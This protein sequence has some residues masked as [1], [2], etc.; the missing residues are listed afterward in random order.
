[1]AANNHATTTHT[2]PT[3]PAAKIHVYGMLEQ[4]P[5]PTDERDAE[6]Q[7]LSPTALGR[8]EEWMARMV[9]ERRLPYASAAVARGG[10][11]VFARGVGAGMETERARVRVF[12]LAHSV[13]AVGLMRLWERGA[14]GLDDPVKRFIPSFGNVKV[15]SDDDSGFAAKATRPITMRHLL[16]HT[17]GL[18]HGYDVKGDTIPIDAIYNA[19]PNGVMDARSLSVVV[20]RLAK[21]PLWFEPG[22][23]FHYSL[24]PLVSMRVLEIIMDTTWDRAV[25]DLVLKPLGMD[26][27]FVLQSDQ[28]PADFGVLPLVMPASSQASMYIPAHRASRHL[29]GLVNIA[30]NERAVRDPGGVM[31]TTLADYVR[32]VDV[33]ANAGVSTFTR[34]RLLSPRTVEMMRS[35]QLS[36]VAGGGGGSG[37]PDLEQ[38]ARVKFTAGLPLRGFGFGLGLGTVHLPGERHGEPMCDGTV[39]WGSISSCMWFHDPRERVSVVFLSGCCFVDRQALDVRGTVAQ[40]VYGGLTRSMVA[41]L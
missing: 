16:T 15:W 25:H 3:T 29:R 41:R 13:V 22:T 34:E 11:V 6:T 21:V 33:L 18:S 8:L 20:A 17:A 27:T 12:G 9:G 32:F 26:D 40:L 37:S 24:A 23:E 10:K 19:Q 36:V 14:F 39:G 7:G 2:S 1:M 4:G 35:N 5:S 31:C 28:D 30:A 38:L